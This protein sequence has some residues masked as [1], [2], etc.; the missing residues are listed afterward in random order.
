MPARMARDSGKWARGGA[1][2]RRRRHRRRR[3]RNVMLLI[4]AL[5]NVHLLIL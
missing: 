1:G 4:N 3:R 2:S 5:E